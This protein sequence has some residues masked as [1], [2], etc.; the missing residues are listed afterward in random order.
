MG[1]GDKKTRRGKIIA[2]SFGVRRPRRKKSSPVIKAVKP[3]E[4]PKKAPRTEVPEI[5]E[6]VVEV[7]A[8]VP[9]PAA[10]PEKKAPRK[11]VKK[12]VEGEAPKEPKPKAPRAKKKTEEK[13]ETLFDQKEEPPQA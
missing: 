2:G 4:K 1:K 7:A 12:A 6:P 8:V 13:G 5:A 11:T 10:V 3:A 9:E